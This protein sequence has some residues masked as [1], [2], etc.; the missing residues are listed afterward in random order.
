[1]EFLNPFFAVVAALGFAFV[2][3]VPQNQLITVGVL[4]F[5]GFFVRVLFFRAGVGIELS[6]LLGAIVIGAMGSFAARRMDILP[7]TVTLAAG[8]PMIPGSIVFEAIKHLIAFVSAPKADFTLLSEATYYASK[9]IFI[10]A[11]LAFGLT[12]SFVLFKRR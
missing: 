12:A 4:A 1:M 8:I 10:L 2:F 11:A 6:V 3:K 5:C 7:H 9:S